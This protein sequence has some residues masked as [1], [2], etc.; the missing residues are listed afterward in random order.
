MRIGGLEPPRLAPLDPK[1]NAATNY[2]ISAPINQLQYIIKQT[3]KTSFL[4]FRSLKRDCKDTK[5]I[6]CGLYSRIFIANFISIPGA[7]MVPICSQVIPICLRHDSDMPPIWFRYD[8]DM[9]PMYIS[10]SYRIYIGSIWEACR[11]HLG[12]YRNHL[13]R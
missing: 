6:S 12:A 9:V 13:G 10:D 1:S 4:L 8:S 11:K 7:L 2:A 5:K 3:F